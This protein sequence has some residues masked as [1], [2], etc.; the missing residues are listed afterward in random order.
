MLAIK[1]DSCCLHMRTILPMS[2]R[3]RVVACR[4]PRAPGW[5]PET[6]QRRVRTKS[7]RAR[8]GGVVSEHEAR[9][10]KAAAL[11]E[12]GWEYAAVPTWPRTHSAKQAYEQFERR[13]T[14]SESIS[15][16][17]VVA[18]RVRALRWFGKLGFVTVED[19]S[20]KLQLQL[21]QDSL[22]ASPDTAAGEVT[23]VAHAK[24]LLD[25][26]D[27]ICARG[28]SMK[29][30]KRGELSLVVS[31]CHLLSKALRPLPEKFHGLR[32]KEARYRRRPL[33]FLTNPRARETIEQR[34]AALRA[35][36]RF[37]ESEGFLEV[38]TPLLHVS[39]GG[40]TARPFTTHHNALD[41]SFALRIAP[42]LHL[43][44][45]LVGGFEKV[46]ELGRVLRNE[47]LSPRH[48]PEF[49]SL[50]VYEAYT[51][52]GRMIELV[53]GMVAEAAIAVQGKT[54]L[55]Y[56]G[57]PL[58][59]T[60]PWRRVTMAA[61]VREHT[62]ID[63]RN[64]HDVAS[65]MSAADEALGRLQFESGNERAATCEFSAN[66][67]TAST[68]ALTGKIAPHM[69][70]KTVGGVMALVFEEA[71]EE[72]L[73]DPTV[74]TEYPL[75]ISPLARQ[76]RRDSRDAAAANQQQCLSLDDGA[77]SSRN[78]GG[79]EGGLVERFEVFVAGRELA[80]AFSELADPTEQRSR[81]EQQAALRA[82]GDS[83]AHVV[84]EDYL[85]ELEQAMPPAGGLGVGMD[86]LVM[87]LTD[88][89][90]IR[91]V[92]AFPTLKPRE[93]VSSPSK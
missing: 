16:L 64:F 19:A 42:E 67:G 55:T 77:Q 15:A 26:G 57:Q 13:L 18:G 54:E 43:K 56:N 45:L 80:N 37:L 23:D 87:L 39:A 72:I 10:Q 88:H 58:D 50:E 93:R 46:F 8:P 2:V 25:V 63:F 84:D 60:P 22:N 34:G 31:D 82:L 47:G 30:T 78:S 36:R 86:R 29:K 83:E 3:Q 53:E 12:A 44:Q 62:G 75:E 69:M 20:G 66:D 49:T 61:L 32:D 7:S 1:F 59:L 35:V 52:Y 89:V 28:T 27:I 24:Q 21:A 17:V 70:P 38:E 91:E 6:L 74:V 33:D 85:V 68:K 11:R 65:A 71:V 51:D 14:P 90:S 76:L 92:I 4:C 81:F 5:V 48:N 9:S 73:W 79:V 40:A 41:Y